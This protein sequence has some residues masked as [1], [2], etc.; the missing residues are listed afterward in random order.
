MG[1]YAEMAWEQEMETRFDLFIERGRR[2][3][4]FRKANSSLWMKKDGSIIAISE[5]ENG[6]LLNSIKMLRRA[7][8]EEYLAYQGLIEE[9]KKRRL[10]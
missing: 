2:F 6:H 7:N 8:Q 5:M 4:D 3:I 9:A 1:E 10:L